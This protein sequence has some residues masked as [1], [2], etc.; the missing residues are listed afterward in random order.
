MAK[1]HHI[2][3]IKMKNKFYAHFIVNIC[4]KRNKK[5]GIFMYIIY[6]KYKQEYKYRRKKL[7]Q[8]CNFFES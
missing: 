2:F 4:I 6:I 3:T 1:Y 7:Y 5:H 8:I